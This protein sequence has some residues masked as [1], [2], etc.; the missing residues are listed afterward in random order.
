MNRP[1]RTLACT[2][3]LLACAAVTVFAQSTTG[4][5]AGNVKDTTGA[6]VPGANV[7]ATESRTSYTRAAVTDAKGNYVMVALPLGSYNVTAEL[8]GFRKTSR[9]GYTLVADGRITADFALELGVLTET[10]EVT[11]QGETVNTT[12]GEIARTVDSTQ[13]QNLALNGRN[14]VQLTTLIPGT[15]ELNPD[16]L[17]IMT[18]LGI[19]TSINGSRNNSTL[20]T[21][22]GGFNMDS[23]SNNSQ[24]S[25]VGV[26]FIEEVSIKTSNFS[27]EYGRNSGA[28][29]NVVTRGGSNTFHGSVFEYLRNE[30]LDA[31]NYFN[32]QKKVAKS[33]LTYNNFGGALGG[34]IIKDK[35]FFF[36]GTEWKQI[37]RFSN[38]SLQTLP[39]SRMRS[40]NFSALTT[41]IKDPLTGLPFPGNIIPANRITTDGRAIAKLYEKMAGTALSYEDVAKANNALFQQANPFRWRQEMVRIDYN[42]NKSHRLTTR[43]LF[44]HYVLTDPY[45]TFIGGNLPTVPTDRNRPG[46][47]VQA[48]DIWTIKPNLLNEIKF[49]YSGNGQKIDPVGDTWA[50]STYGFQFPQ[51]YPAGGTYENSVPNAT[52]Q[53]FAGWLS[54]SSALVSPTQD[55]ALTDTLT[56]LRDAHTVK[57]GILYVYNTKKQNGRSNYAGTVNFN[58]TGNPNT[59]GNSFADA[60]LGNFRSYSE[61]QLDP[62]GYFRFKQFEAFATDD[63][64]VRSN[65]SIEV[66]LR[67]GYHVPT[68]TLGNNLTG[69]DPAQYDPSKAV[70]LNTNGTVVPNSGNRFNGLVRAGEVPADQVAN[71]PNANSPF[72]Q[73]LPIAVNPGLYSP[74]HLLMPRFSFAWTPDGSGKTAVRGGIGLS[75]DRPE[76]NLYFSLPNNP[77][78][79][80]SSSF[81][82]GNLSNPGGGTAAALAPFGQVDSIDPNL[83][84][85]RSWNWSLSAQRELGFWGM[86]GELAY[87]GAAGQQ[88]LRQP[89]INQPSFAELEANATGAKLPVNYLRPYKG[90]SSIRQRLSDANSSYNAMQV[91]LTKRKGDLRFTLNYTLSKATDNASGNG[92]N[93]EDYLNKDY[94]QGPGDFDRTHIFVTTWSYV[95][96]I[97]KNNK[98]ALGAVFGGWEIS[99]IARYQTGAPL[100]VTADT[101]IG[102]RRA[103]LVPGQDPYLSEPIN[104]TTGA[105]QWLNPAAFVASPEGRRGNLTRGQFRGPAYSVL[106]LSLRKRFAIKGNVRLQVQADLFNAL[107]RVNWGN[108]ATNL[109]GAGFGVITTTQPPRNIQLGARVTF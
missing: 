32:I 42:I 19:N 50:R 94:N 41:Q 14:Y 57:T 98:G 22:D 58:P 60:L 26:D 89:D 81:E 3:A 51:L 38:P 101:S 9:S 64:K 68:Y 56:W 36:A 73:S 97:L 53:N 47:N 108:P 105:V 104:P 66:G 100:T 61:A 29:V 49:N 8:S 95:L 1:L 109:S 46:R 30:G 88:L 18:G 79:A 25:N 103:D 102:N 80:D 85:P 44:D 86:F 69:F 106:D 27:A 10:V 71:V 7:V 21:V 43:L 96:P 78:F 35:L 33:A 40:G 90:Y 20:L 13:V 45:G 83:V 4:R 39:D 62:L 82:N 17:S 59:T 37:D 91:Y 75:Y 87:V 63:W 15:P 34:P 28:A 6:V 55:F 16:A 12:S 67:Y 24:I 70:K 93:P 11:V 99:G 107:D 23:G 52:L 48:A 76:G 92:D 84:I 5:I 74:Q 54:A 2:A 31:N 65:L 77:P 72:V